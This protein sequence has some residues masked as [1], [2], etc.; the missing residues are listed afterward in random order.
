MT[1]TKQMLREKRL[2]KEEGYSSDEEVSMVPRPEGKATRDR[3]M[4]TQSRVTATRSRETA[5]RNWVTT[6]RVRRV[7][8]KERN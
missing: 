2:A 8:G 7:T 5:T 1:K 4:R 3:M 6:T